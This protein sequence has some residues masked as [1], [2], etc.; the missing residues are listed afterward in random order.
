MHLEEKKLSSEKIFEGKV[1]KLYRDN[2]LL[3]DNSEATREVIRHPGGVCVVALTENNEILM[4]KQFRYP[5]N[6]IMTEVPAGKL[7]W[8]EEPFECGKRELLEET[9]F[10]AEEYTYLGT[11]APTPAYC[12]EIIHI[13]MAKKLTLGKQKLDEGEFLDVEKISLEKA[14]EMVMNG[15]ITDA[16]TQLA[17]LK[18]KLILDK[19]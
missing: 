12:S 8:G 10:T 5:H 17:I 1:V 16:K 7:E 6:K 18:A 14:V 2:V 4:V 19:E 13:Y 9:G 15:E 11:L 3:E